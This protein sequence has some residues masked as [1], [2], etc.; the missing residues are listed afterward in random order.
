MDDKKVEV[1][2][3]ILRYLIRN[4]SAQDTIKGVEWW[5][6]ERKKKYERHLLKKALDMM[7]RHGLVIR[8]K[9]PYSQT[10][11][12]LYRPRRKK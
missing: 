6:L 8:R 5:L 3:D 12:K 1:A 10:F 4:P 2:Y 7:V 11:Y 9:K